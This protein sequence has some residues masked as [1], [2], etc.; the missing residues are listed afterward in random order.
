M[1]LSK[2][3]TAARPSS[4][5]PPFSPTPE[6]DSARLLRRVVGLHD[7]WMTMIPG[8]LFS[9]GELRTNLGGQV[10]ALRQF[11]IQVR[12]ARPYPAH[13]RTCTHN[14]QGQHQRHIGVVD[15]ER[16]AEQKPCDGDDHRA[17][18]TEKRAA[19]GAEP[20]RVEDERH[21]KGKRS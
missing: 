13:Q 21:Q 16:V 19:P 12:R 1:M 3:R 14:D 4:R 18:D 9:A 20:W 10:T 7:A 6:S 2:G 8:T 15:A 5:A 17:E 11:P